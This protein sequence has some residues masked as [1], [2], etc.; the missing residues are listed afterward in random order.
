VAKPPLSSETGSGTGFLTPEQIAKNAIIES[1][2]QAM[3]LVQGVEGTSRNK[4]PDDIGAF[5]DVWEQVQAYHREAEENYVLLTVASGGFL[6]GH[7]PAPNGDEVTSRIDVSITQDDGRGHPMQDDPCCIDDPC[8]KMG[9][10]ECKCGKCEP[11]IVDCENPNDHCFDGIQNC[12][13]TAIDCGGGC[14]FTGGKCVLPTCPSCNDGIQNCGESAIDCGGLCAA[15]PIEASPADQQCPSC[16]DG[17]QNCDEEGVDC[18]GSC[19]P[20][21]AYEC[22]CSMDYDAP[23]WCRPEKREPVPDD[24]MSLAASDGKSHEAG[25]FSDVS[26]DGVTK[27]TPVEDVGGIIRSMNTAEMEELN[28]LEA[29]SANMTSVNGTDATAVPITEAPIAVELYDDWGN[30]I[31]TE[32]ISTPP[33]DTAAPLVESITTEV[34]SSETIPTPE[35]VPGGVT[36]SSDQVSM[37]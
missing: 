20:C 29:L 14:M 18:G 3:A 37:E 30:P 1:I 27:E 31:V 33:S 17:L 34:P 7:R 9:G 16:N 23:C 6:H 35:I 26:L 5:L 15:C 13:E 28:R 12:N 24:S 36:E 32:A 19:I 25:V 11:K 8:H 22:P 21:E 2:S 4:T 10:M